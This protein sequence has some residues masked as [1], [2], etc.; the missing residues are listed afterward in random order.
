MTDLR[1]YQHCT[2]PVVHRDRVDPQKPSV[3]IEITML[4]LVKVPK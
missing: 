3:A 2:G 1:S 4:N